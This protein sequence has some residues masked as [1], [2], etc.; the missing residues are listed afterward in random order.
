MLNGS[1]SIRR[2]MPLAGCAK[3]PANT[4]P[5]AFLYDIGALLSKAGFEHYCQKFEG[6]ISGSMHVE[7]Y[8]KDMRKWWEYDIEI[9]GRL[10]LR[11]PKKSGPSVALTAEFQGTATKFKS[12]DDALRIG[13][14][15]RQLLF[16]SASPQFRARRGPVSVSTE[17]KISSVQAKLPS[18]ASGI[19]LN[20]GD[21]DN[22][23]GDR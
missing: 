10:T 19:M 8:A 11:Y 16:A 21:D 23:R 17:S 13:F 20:L 9:N 1:A 3:A 2:F 4:T 12:W 18:R 14:P 15:E 7:A 22:V 5:H 6:P